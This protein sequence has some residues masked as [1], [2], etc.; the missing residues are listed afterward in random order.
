M[1]GRRFA[2]L[3]PVPWFLDADCLKLERSDGGRLRL[4]DSEGREERRTER[5]SGPGEQDVLSGK[6][7]H[8][9]R[10]VLVTTCPRSLP[11]A[12]GWRRCPALKDA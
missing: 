3:A 6:G 7:W 2:R 8:L 5:P 1:L 4:Q 11:I 9:G 10:A 12:K